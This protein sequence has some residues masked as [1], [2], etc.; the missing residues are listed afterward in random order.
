[1]MDWSYDLLAEPERALLRRLSVFSDG[2]T[3]SAAEEVCSGEAVPR[4]DILDL[5]GHLVEASVVVFDVDFAAR[6]RLLE[7]VRQYGFD[8]LVDAGEE[9]EASLRHA[10]HFRV[11]SADVSQALLAGDLT[12][13]D[14]TTEDLSNFRA[15]MSWSLRTGRGLLALEIACNMR[16]YFW[17]QGMFRE[18]LEWL[19]SALDMVDDDASPFVAI[20]TAYALTEATNIGGDSPIRA[21]ADRARGLLAISNDDLATGYLANSLA[22]YEMSADVRR[23]DQLYAEATW[24]LRR[25]GDYRWFAPVQNRFITSWLMNS[26]DAEGEILSLVDEAGSLFTPVRATIGR[27]LF[28]VLAEEY[29]EVIE[30]TEVESPGDEWARIMLLLYRIQAQRATGRLDDAIES[31]GR[32]TTQAGVITD[33]W[34]GWHAGMV[35]LQ[36]G[37]LE[38]AIEGFAAPGAYDTESPATSDRANVAWFWSMIAQRRGGHEDAAVLFG[39]AEAAAEKASV[40]LLTF[41]RR[42]VEESQIAVE[43]ALGEERYRVLYKQ[44]AVTAWEDLPLIHSQGYGTP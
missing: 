27:T 32:F 28:K 11:V 31:I 2:F 24:L 42:L 7:T 44:G 29:E 34:R 19:S 22:S 33:G 30:A 38:A 35:H 3:Y 43:E 20:G 16:T 41:D 4:P 6:Y 25:A 36:L 15:A 39:F 9:E 23:A 5:L 26:R 8:R 21:L 12:P 37:D 1:M 13:T 10:E 17:N 14:A 18:S 40:E